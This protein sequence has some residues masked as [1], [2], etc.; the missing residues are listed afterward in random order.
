MRF[1][2][3]NP[4]TTA[5]AATEAT[6]LIS[7]NFSRALRRLEEKG[8]IRRERD[9]DDARR[10]RLYPTEQAQQNLR[11]LHVLWSELLEGTVADP[12]DVE[13][14]IVLLRQMETSLGARK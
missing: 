2:D 12:A 5:G 4:G 7:S 10:F 13:R 6:R 3:R 1:I 9:P 11:R 8:L 14:M